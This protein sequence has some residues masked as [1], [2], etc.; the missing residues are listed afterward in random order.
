[1]LTF[2]HVSAGY[3]ISR[4]ANF[5]ALWFIVAANIFDLDFLIYGVNH[6]GNFTH[7]PLMGLFYLFIFYLFLKKKLLLKFFLW[8]GIALLSHLILD[9]LSYWLYLLGWE[10][11]LSQQIN[12][13]FPL[14]PLIPRN[15]SVAETLTNYLVIT[16]KLFYLEI[17]FI[18]WAIVTWLRVKIRT[19]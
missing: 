9:D 16:P 12:W 13:L 17:F 10:K 2:G 6:H 18:F 1:M 8:M 5:P 19:R 11:S 7:T 15:Y 14:T 3:L 4:K